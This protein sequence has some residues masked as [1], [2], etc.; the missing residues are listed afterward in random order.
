M[1]LPE[2]RFENDKYIV[3]AGYYDLTRSDKDEIKAIIGKALDASETSD[4]SGLKYD[5][6]IVYRSL[7]NHGLRMAT[8][9]DKI[10]SKYVG[11]CLFY[12]NS[13]TAIV[14]NTKDILG[15]NAIYSESLEIATYL[16]YCIAAAG[17]KARVETIS[18]PTNIKGLAILF[19]SVIDM[20]KPLITANELASLVHTKHTTY[21]D[22]M[23]ITYDV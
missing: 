21:K 9:Y 12:I 16:M 3:Y 22:V 17:I 18:I 14:A 6:D 19:D 5:R 13:S 11:S 2:N 15:V 1:K 20:L 4:L 10:N 7:E 8:A 23:R